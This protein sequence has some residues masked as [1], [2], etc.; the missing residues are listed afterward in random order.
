[1][2]AHHFAWQ[3]RTE[4]ERLLG[5]R[6]AV[7]TGGYRVITTLDWDAQKLAEKYV[8]A[9]AVI[10]HL[11]FGR[12]PEGDE[13]PRSSGRSTGRWVSNLRCKDLH[14]GALV[15]LD[16]RTGDV[17]AYVG[18]GSY[19]RKDLESRQFQPQHDAA[20]AYPAAGLGVQADRLRHGVRR[21][22]D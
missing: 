2:R 19:E 10:P 8:Y 15:A 22:R 13:P 3:V 7:E 1:M 21:A 14:N 6:D 5:G 9:A 4:L 20:A 16:Y 17:I 12:G 18:S 11:P